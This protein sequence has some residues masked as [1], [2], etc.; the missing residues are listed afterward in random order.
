MKVSDYI[1][2]FIESKNVYDVFG[3]PGG[4]VT[5]LMDSFDKSTNITQ[6]ILYNEQGVSFAACG[7]AQISNKTGICFATS[8]PGVT[9][10][11]TGIANAYYDSIP[12]IFIT[13]QVNTYE[14]KLN[15]SMRQKAFQEMPVVDVVKK[16]SKY[17]VSIKNAE[18]IPYE[19]EK[20]YFISH[21]KRKGSVVIDIPMDIQRTDIDLDKCKK[22]IGQDNSFPY[23]LEV[24][25]NELSMANR[26]LLIVGNGIKQQGAEDLLDLFCSKYNIP[27]VCS[28]PGV[29]ILPSDCKKFFGFI[30]SYGHRS[31]NILTQKADLIISIGTRLSS[32]QISLNRKEFAPGAKI[33]RIDID[34]NELENNIH[35]DDINIQME[36]TQFLK[37]TIDTSYEYTNSEWLDTA[38]QIKE[39]LKDLDIKNNNKI[40][41]SISQI[42]P[43]DAVITT[44]V[45]QNQVWVAQSFN[46]KKKQKVIFST[47][48][49]AMGYA[50]P[51]AVGSY[52]AANRTVISINGD[53]GFQMNIQELATISQKKLPIKIIVINNHSLGM[54]RHFQEMYFESNFALTKENK[55]YITCDFVEIAN[56]YGIEAYNVDINSIEKYRDLFY[57]SKPYLFNVEM[58]DSTYVFPKLAMGK[59]LYDQEPLMDRD[60]LR[61]IIEL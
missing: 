28:M 39:N 34:E 22:F 36:I 48:H 38:T 61:K 47:G 9:N 6:H 37:E 11:I 42:V 43:D 7:Y 41:D 52:F 26:P 27:I 13:G 2:K 8:G 45:G 56:A 3:Y 31:A 32:R 58:C 15:D 35:K 44:D 50:L 16:I 53:G 60:L 46:F 20:A 25:Y 12:V 5:H 30:G 40:M 18:D 51:S 55:G 4:M 17:A 24:F 23:N 59:P 29:G 19:L 33:I 1:V 57:D 10:L 49:G 14:Q 21:N 54:I